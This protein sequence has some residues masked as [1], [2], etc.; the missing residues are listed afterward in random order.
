MRGTYSFNKLPI[1]LTTITKTHINYFPNNLLG[2]KD[3]FIL[4]FNINHKKITKN[5]LLN[6]GNQKHFLIFILR[7]LIII[8]I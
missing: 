1:N 8:K 7:I 6:V 3:K 5:I 2:I 4:D